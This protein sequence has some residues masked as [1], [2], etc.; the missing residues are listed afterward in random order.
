MVVITLMSP[1]APGERRPTGTEPRMSTEP[2]LWAVRSTGWL[3]VAGRLRVPELHDAWT[4]PMHDESAPLI[5][6]VKHRLRKQHGLEIS[7]ISHA[8]VSGKP[9]H[10]V[11]VG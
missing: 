1:N 4:A 8:F 5:P 2:A 3:G 6:G 9:Q 11:H 10:P 7:P